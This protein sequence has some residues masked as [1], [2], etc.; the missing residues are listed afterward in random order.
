MSERKIV[1]VTGC[2]KGGIGYEYCRAFAEQNCHV[3]ASDITHRMADMLDLKS[4]KNNIDTMELD[5]CCDES[6]SKGVE[7][8][9]SKCG[10]IDILINNAG[11]GSTGPLA[12]LPL[13]AI[14][15]AWEINTLGQIRLVQHVVPHMASR[16]SGSIVNVGSVVGTVSTPWAGSYCASK[17]AVIAMSNSLRLELRPFG[18]NVVQVLPGAVRSNLGSANMER[19]GGY[20]W[21]LYKGFKEVIEERARASQGAKATDG[22]VFARHVAK[23]VLSPRP[24]RQI[25]FGHM[26]ALFAFLSCSPM[27]VRDLFFSNRFGLNTRH[28]EGHIELLLKWGHKKYHSTLP[29]QLLGKELNLFK[30]DVFLVLFGFWNIR[31]TTMENDDG[32]GSENNWLGF[33]LSPHM[34]LDVPSD[35]HQHETTQPPSAA[36]EA[37]P[38]SFYHSIPPLPSY[39]HGFYYYGLEA[40]SVGLYSPLPVM[41]LKSDGSLYVMEP[42]SRSHSQQQPQAMVTSSTPKLENFLGSSS[43]GTPHYECNAR[44]AMP[45]SLNS[46]IY[47]NQSSRME[48]GQE[49]EA[50]AFSAYY[51]GFRSNDMMLEGPNQNEISEC[52]V[53]QVPNMG[54]DGGG[55]VKRWVM[56]S[57]SNPSNNN[58]HDSKMIIGVEDNNGGESGSIGSMAYGDLQS[59]SLSM[60]PGS[61]SSCVTSSQRASPSV[62]DSVA[63]ETKKRGPEKVDQKQIVHRKSIDTFGQRTSQYRGVTRHRWTGRYEAHLWDNSCKKEGQSRKGR[64]GGYDMEEKAARAYDLAALKYWGPSTH[65][66]FPLENYQNQLEDMKNMTRQEYVAHLRRKS[67]GFSRGASMYRGVTRHHQHGR[68]QAR[69]G[70]VAGNKDLYLGTFSTQE[71]AAEAYD[72][73][74]IKFRGVNAVTNFDITRY[75]VEKIMGSSNLLSGELARRNREIITD[76]GNN[77]H[78]AITT[79]TTTFDETQEAILMQKMSCESQSNP[80]QWITELDQN[81]PRID[82]YSYKSTQ[83]FSVPLDNMIHQVEDSNKNNN[84]MSNPSSLVTSLSSSREVSPDKPS[85]PVLSEM[86]SLVTSLRPPL[87][88]P[89]VPVFAGWTDA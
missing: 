17:A 67:S 52:N 15:K 27:W 79:K 26:T 21:K 83:S 19:L 41:P 42:L 2:A 85:L 58:G 60:S 54:E 84:N 49:I 43:M 74:A 6:V 10:R 8:V 51:S 25:V 57:S 24:P 72:I 20:E 44:E 30:L 29:H 66:N 69:I 81:P 76:A 36:G 47:C 53:Q 45:L 80:S 65:I 71:E 3:F 73:A 7:S 38:A 64:Q 9:I 46:M 1:L 31:H 88:L 32:G 11:I 34:N 16:G 28:W 56:R 37:V 87:S 13:D 59:L 18:I 61:Q 12:E 39:G 55:G 40:E 48:Q 82:A 78:Q 22:A 77:D 14:R 75:D 33:S 4:D 70:R 68:W 86:P 62:I 35:S 63:L 89:H 23:K 5:V 50:Q